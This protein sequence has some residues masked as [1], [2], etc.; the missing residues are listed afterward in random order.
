MIAVIKIS[1][2]IILWVDHNTKKEEVSLYFRRHRLSEALLM[3]YKY[4]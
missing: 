4:W 1:G 2:L 3:T